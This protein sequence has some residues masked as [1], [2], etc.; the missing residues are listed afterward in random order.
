[1]D[2][3]KAF[4]LGKEGRL[5]YEIWPD[6]FF[7]FE[8]RFRVFFVFPVNIAFFRVNQLQIIFGLTLG[9]LGV[10]RVRT[11]MGHLVLWWSK[12]QKLNV[13]CAS[14]QRMGFKTMPNGEKILRSWIVYSLVNEEL[15]YF[16]CG[17]FAVNVSETTSKFVTGVDKWC[18]LRLKLHNH[19]TSEE[20]LCW[21]GKC[22]ALAAGLQLHK[23]LMPKF[24]CDGQG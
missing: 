18:K 17:L 13:M 5:C 22:E 4:H 9:K 20:R 11:K 24:C 14:Q 2:E 6:N 7:R 15:F 23:Q 3:K 16:C 12:M 1:M 8:G 21:L 19:E 10:L